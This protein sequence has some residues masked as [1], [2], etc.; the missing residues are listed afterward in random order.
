[1]SPIQ[2]KFIQ[3]SVKSLDIYK[4]KDAFCYSTTKDYYYFL[5]EKI[6]ALQSWTTQTRL[7]ECMFF[8]QDPKNNEK[9][10]SF[11]F[12]VLGVFSSF[13]LKSSIPNWCKS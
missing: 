10:R 8:P 5:N 6:S 13:E 7:I 11:P 3:N 12:I 9:K 4:D 1:L 2:Y